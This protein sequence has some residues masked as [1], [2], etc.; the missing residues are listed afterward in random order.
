MTE[1]TMAGKYVLITGGTSGIGEITAQQL[2]QMGASVIITGRDGS[3]CQKT[4]AKI[5]HHV[6]DACIDYLLVDLSNLAQVR[7]LSKQFED[8]YSQLDIL[9]NNAGA[10]YLRRHVSVD[11]YEL[12]F[13]TNHLGH[14][15][16][17]H[18]LLPLLKSAAVNNRGAHII[19]VSSNAHKGAEIKFDDLQSERNYQAMRVYG[20]SKLAN[21][22]FTFELDRRIKGYNVRV[23]A[24]HPGLIR[25]NIGVN[26]NPLAKIIYRLFVYPF[27][28]PTEEG[29]RTSVYLASSSD[30]IDISGEY[31][32]GCKPVQ[33]DP[34]AYDLAVA[35]RLWNVSSDLVKLE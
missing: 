1:K 3:R 11:G 24:L 14:F 33:A 9:I 23:N 5:K 18:R 4:I 25:T 32:V 16:L 35:E 30:S 28:M 20:M 27:A 2:A 6:P 15:L 22:L 10:I 19:N 31:F 8:K 26:H 12:T 17:T 29:A 7:N 21:I 13:A 34:V